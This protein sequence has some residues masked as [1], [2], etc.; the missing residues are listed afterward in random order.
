MTRDAHLRM[1][2][3]SEVTDA[4]E[5]P[6]SGPLDIDE[7]F[8][9]LAPYVAAV[10]L[11]LLGRRD[12]V[13]DLVQD[14]FLAAHRARKKLRVRHEAR[15]WLT[16]VA[17][18]CAR[19]RLRFRYL[20]G[21]LRLDD[22]APEL[23]VTAGASPEDQAFLAQVYAVLDRLPVDERLAWTLRYVQGEKLAVVAEL[24]GC[25]LATAKRRIA[26]AQ[27]AITGEVA[28]SPESQT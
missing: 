15:R 5:A 2:R 8:R 6:S 25:S 13:E 19:R 24:M 22:Q 21:W 3:E 10:G 23:L 27:E 4:A 26:S 16:V 17:V 12:E 1:V 9:E 18:R 20:R 28:D 11:R 7:L 14:V